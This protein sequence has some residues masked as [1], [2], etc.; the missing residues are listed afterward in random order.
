MLSNAH[1]HIETV[2][3]NH[4]SNVLVVTPTLL[5]LIQPSDNG[6]KRET[7]AQDPW[8]REGT[9][10]ENT[11]GLQALEWRG[12]GGW[13]SVFTNP[14]GKNFMFTETQTKHPREE[15][16]VVKEGV[17]LT[18]VWRNSTHQVWLKAIIN[19]N[20]LHLFSFQQNTTRSLQPAMFFPVINAPKWS[21][22]ASVQVWSDEGQK[23]QRM[24]E[25][26]SFLPH[27][28]FAISKAKISWN[29]T[30]Y[31]IKFDKVF[32][33]LES[34]RIEHVIRPYASCKKAQSKQWH[35]QWLADTSS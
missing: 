21:R 3:A 35:Q 22:Q 30:F 19:R 24:L 7:S 6:E 16:T 12:G 26:H 28:N 15:K 13:V 33:L 11:P 1:R 18:N 23:S 27:I 25:F 32:K 31:K 34:I 5:L 2:R 4:M 20:P 8:L 9:L 17:H 14:P 29:M 10:K